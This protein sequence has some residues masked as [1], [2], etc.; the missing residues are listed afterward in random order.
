MT[1]LHFVV[2]CFWASHISDHS[3]YSATNTQT[4]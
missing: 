4:P 3:P 2:Q 1:T